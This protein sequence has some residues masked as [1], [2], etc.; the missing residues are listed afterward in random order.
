MQQRQRSD[1]IGGSVEDQLSPLRAASVLQRD[2]IHAGTRDQTSQLFYLRHGCVRRFEGT[3][4]RVALDVEADMA[5]SDW[6][7]GGKRRA[8]DDMLHV[9][10][11]DLL[12][13][14]AVLHR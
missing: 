4:P 11:D 6:M 14:D 10:G 2:H 5:G 13:A 1:G 3:N 7:P 8:T 12:V 9:F